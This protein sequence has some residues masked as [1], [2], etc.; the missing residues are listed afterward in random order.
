[1]SNFD[2][3]SAKASA[4]M[5]EI[6]QIYR[7]GNKTPVS[8]LGLDALTSYQTK[9]LALQNWWGHQPFREGSD[10]TELRISV[11]GVLDPALKSLNQRNSNLTAAVPL[12]ELKYAR[13]KELGFWIG[14]I[15]SVA[16]LTAVIIW[17][18]FDYLSRI[19]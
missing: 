7:Q 6:S 10:E 9:L 5:K 14:V 4:D 8:R 1:M 2:S 12:R 11:Y 15:A 17:E 19:K 18:L 3:L 13:I 16:T